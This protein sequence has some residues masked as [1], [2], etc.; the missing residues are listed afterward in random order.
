MF[1]LAVKN[2]IN[3][4]GTVYASLKGIPAGRG[5]VNNKAYFEAAGASAIAAMALAMVNPQD[6]DYTTRASIAV[7]DDQLTG[8]Y[9]DYLQALDGFYVDMNDPGNAYSASA[10]TQQ[11]LKTMIVETRAQL[12]TLALNARQ[13]R[14]VVLDRDSNLIVETHK[15][16]GLDADDVNLETFR[17]INGI[18]NRK[19]F[20]IPKGTMIRYYAA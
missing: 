14:Q 5:T 7:V 15:Y 10:E 19:L 6:S 9:N 1:S 4:L 13:E 12:L 16:M 11:V 2:R 17:T 18:R 20:K 3:L 8:Y